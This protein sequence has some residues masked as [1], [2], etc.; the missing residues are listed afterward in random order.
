MFTRLT[1][2]VNINATPPVDGW[3]VACIMGWHLN[4]FHLEENMAITAPSRITAKVTPPT[5]KFSLVC[6]DCDGTNTERLP[7]GVVV[8]CLECGRAFN[9]ES[10][11]R[12][13]VK[14]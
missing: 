2:N 8:S 12:R 9:G 3:L 1:T 14:P 11:E 10:A 6:P 7:G 4:R 13:E 5:I